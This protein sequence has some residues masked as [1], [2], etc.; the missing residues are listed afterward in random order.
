MSHPEHHVHGLAGDDMPPDW[1]PLTA[2]ELARVLDAYPALGAPRRIAWHSP[3]PLSTAALVDTRGGRVFVKR[4][5]RSVR[6]VASLG[7]EHA[8]AAWLAAHDVSVPAVL[9]D[10]A[11]H[12]A[13]AHG[14]W[15][16]EVH[17]PARGVDVYRDTMSWVPLDD[18]QRARRAG[19]MLARLHQ[20]A[21]GYDAPQRTTHRLVARSELL[22]AADP[23][24]ALQAQLD[25]RPDLA[26][27]VSGRPWQAE[28]AA[29][30]T[31]QHAGIAARLRARPHCWT[32]G[33]WHV[34]NLCW[35]GD[36]ADAAITEVLDF[37][38]SART[39]ALFDLATAIERN[40]IAWL[41]PGTDLA[42]PATALALIDGYRAIRALD[43]DD[44]ALLA[45]LLPIVHV[46]FAI[47]EVDYFFGATHSRAHADVAW[48]TFLR[49]HAVWFRTDDGRRLLETVRAA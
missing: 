23:V 1:P 2:A 30:F 5:H 33:D 31:P 21:Q 48:D 40:A 22:A 17:A 35:S 10:A 13:T 42:H 14:D 49:G 39:F 20:A 24:A 37:G 9:A 16:Y 8:F 28:L 47:S 12:T 41:E 36:G 3:R 25:E 44:L 7:E 32:H 4:H 29:V 43:G 19:A 15:V 11:G 18:A 46:D 27:Y 38:L 34:S 6:S 26:A 45:D